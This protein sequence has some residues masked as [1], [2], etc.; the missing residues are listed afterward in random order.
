MSAAASTG[1]VPR[2]PFERLPLKRGTIMQRVLQ[3]RPRENAWIEVNNLLAS[4]DE[5]RDVRPEQVARIAERYRMPFRG[6]FCGRLERLYR[7]YLLYC[8]A[9][10]RLSSEELSDL[11]HLKRILRLNDRALCEIHETV[12]K[13]VYSMSVDAAL[14]DGHIDAD[15]REFLNTLQHHLAISSAVVDGILQSKRRQ[16]EH[17]AA[18]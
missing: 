1:I 7:D 6:E 14:A 15:E 3:K 12:S 9:D 2:R 4:V 11:A 5:V 10:A 18:E 17:D 8:L 13:H 16:L